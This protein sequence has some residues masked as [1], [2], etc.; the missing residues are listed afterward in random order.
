VHQYLILKAYV[1]L[2]EVPFNIDHMDNY[3]NQVFQMNED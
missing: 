3:I 1:I 2:N